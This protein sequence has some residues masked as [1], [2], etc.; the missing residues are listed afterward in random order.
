MKLIPNTV[1]MEEWDASKPLHGVRF[2]L[3]A[4]APY[5]DYHETRAEFNALVREKAAI[6]FEESI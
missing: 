4:L 2:M 5:R 6:E 3:D 1:G